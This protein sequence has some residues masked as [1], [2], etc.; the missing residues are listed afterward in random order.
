MKGRMLRILR[1]SSWILKPFLCLALVAS[2][3][4]TSVPLP[5]YA[6]PGLQWMAARSSPF[7][8]QAMAGRPFWWMGFAGRI[9]SAV[10][11]M[12]ISAAVLAAEQVRVSDTEL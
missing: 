11:A 1:F 5:S 10:R 4:L 2:L 12:R 3:V 6:L 7:Q 8:T 9:P